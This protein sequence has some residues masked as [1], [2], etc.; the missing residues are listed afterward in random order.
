MGIFV[1]SSS[2]ISEGKGGKLRGP[3]GA[4]VLLPPATFLAGGPTIQKFKDDPCLTAS[5]SYVSMIVF[6]C[7]M[8]N[9]RGDPFALLDLDQ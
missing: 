2:S 6:S 3:V 4:P 8:N 5:R 1:P 7:I 9:C